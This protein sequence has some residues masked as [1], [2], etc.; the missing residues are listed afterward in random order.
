MK[1]ILLLGAGK[2][3]EMITHLLSQTGDYEV[4]VADISEENLKKIPT[5]NN[6]NILSLDISNGDKLVE[7]MN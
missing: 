6:V 5:S 7:V 1:K 3:G 2:I 4:T